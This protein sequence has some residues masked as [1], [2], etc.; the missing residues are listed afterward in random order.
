MNTTYGKLKGLVM[1]DENSDDYKMKWRVRYTWN[2]LHCTAWTV[3]KER[4]EKF[5]ENMGD[6]KVLID[7]QEVKD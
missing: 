5:A 2:G 3:S 4:A 6:D 7:V 1:S